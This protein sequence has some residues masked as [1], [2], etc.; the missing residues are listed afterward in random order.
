[1]PFVFSP[2]TYDAE[3]GLYRFGCYPAARVERWTFWIAESTLRKL[4][5]RL[6]EGSE[7]VFTKLR[8]V[9]H[10]AALARMASGDADVEHVLTLNDFGLVG[11]TDADLPAHD[12]AAS[13]RRMGARS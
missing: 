1:M 6:P 10:Q 11:S 9:V 8:D 5:S 4:A 3:R 2:E 13:C 7:P 12:N